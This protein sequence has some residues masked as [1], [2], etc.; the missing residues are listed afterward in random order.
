MISN[1]CTDTSAWGPSKVCKGDR[2]DGTR[3]VGGR[4]EGREEGRREGEGRTRQC[5]GVDYHTC[6]IQTNTNKFDE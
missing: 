6:Y 1:E 5:T 4:G 3:E 2:R